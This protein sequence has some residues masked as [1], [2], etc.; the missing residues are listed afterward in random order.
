[1]SS[2]IKRFY[3]IGKSESPIKYRRSK[4]S[5]CYEL[6]ITITGTPGQPWTDA[7][8]DQWRAATKVQRSYKEEVVEKLKKLDESSWEV[9]QYG[10]L[11]H[12]PDK[13]PL[14][15]VKSKSWSDDRP[16]VMVTGGVH[17]Y[18]TSGV[19][20][21]ILFIQTEAAKYVKD[22]NVLVFPCISPWGYE[23]IQRWNYQLLDPNRSF[24]SDSES[25]TN[26]SKQL[27]AFVDGLHAD[28]ICHVDLHE[29]TDTDATEF[30]PAK[31]AK[32]GLDYVRG[33]IPDG[34]YLVGD[35]KNEGGELDFLTA[36]IES[37]KKVTHIAPPD[38]GKILGD[39]AVREGIVLVPAK[40]LGLCGGVTHA[41]YTTTTEVYPDSPKA[42]DEICNRAQVA[43]VTGAFDYVMANR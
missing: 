11:P 32:K 28:I 37:V 19:Q 8:S 17:G 14:Y 16:T 13:Y 12:D 6:T 30:R 24:K 33:V 27:M 40:E 4:S 20:G 7:E 15:A 2:D 31:F 1:M 25:Q 29:T 5:V 3:P 26:E 38:D 34:F 18:E 41:K 36:I 23:C 9:V 42:S 22:V 35:S 10:S 39:E 21:S 43:A